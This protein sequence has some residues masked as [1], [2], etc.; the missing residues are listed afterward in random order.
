MD[1]AKVEAAAHAGFTSDEVTKLPSAILVSI[2]QNG[3]V[4]I[5]FSKEIDF[6]P[7]ILKPAKQPKN[8]NS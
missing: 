7:E 5:N 6:P 4:V 1:L 8:I 3:E 2:S